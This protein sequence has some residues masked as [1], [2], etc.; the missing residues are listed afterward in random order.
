[1]MNASIH[2][3]RTLAEVKRLSLAGLEGPKLLRQAAERLK[4][5]VP[6]EAYCASTVDPAS[7]LITH[8][9]AEGIGD[10]EERSEV[11]AVF[12]DRVYFEEDVDQIA[13]MLRDGR[14][15]QL[16]S[17]ATGG[18]LDHSLRYREL[19][20]PLGFG[21][22]LGS[23]FIEGSLWGGMDLIREA[24]GPDFSNEEV[25]LMKRVAPHV[26]AGLKAAALRS[27]S[28]ASGAPD[29]TPGVL[30]LDPGGRVISHTHSAERLLSELEDLGLA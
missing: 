5:A 24:G 20:R 22:E 13:A 11:G 4:L 28:P 2:Q 19:L 1:M 3:E 7:N 21:H 12:F 29:G 18:E 26:G 15:V 23:L 10:E 9:I 8:S 16:L 25:A 14:P 6:F 17:E 30:T 27:R